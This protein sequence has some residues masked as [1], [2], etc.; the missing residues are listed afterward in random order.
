MNFILHVI[1]FQSVSDAFI[2]HTRNQTHPGLYPKNPP[3]LTLLQFYICL[4]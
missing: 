3:K 4:I 1:R 2:T